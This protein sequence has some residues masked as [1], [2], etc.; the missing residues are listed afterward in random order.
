[1][2][3]AYVPNPKFQIANPKQIQISKSKGTGF[4]VL[5]FPFGTFVFVWDLGFGI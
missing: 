5:D 2:D 3:G 4:F 1:V